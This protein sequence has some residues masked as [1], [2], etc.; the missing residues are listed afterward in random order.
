MLIVAG[1]LT[2]AGQ[3]ATDP[4]LARAERMLGF[5]IE[6]QADSLYSNMSGQV[7]SLVKP[8][9]LSGIMQ[10]LEPQTGSY[11]SHGAWEVQEIMG[12][13]CYVSEVAFEKTSL[14]AL[15]LFDP[16]GKML[17]IQFVPLEAIKK[18]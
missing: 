16:E 13:P 6:N 2:A 3:A 15:V 11:R 12:Q 18:Q 10:Q 8:E 9:Q 1:A 17:G 14:G 5:V 4:N 7:K